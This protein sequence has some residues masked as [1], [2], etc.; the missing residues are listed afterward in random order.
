MIY[1]KPDNILVFRSASIVSATGKKA[2]IL[3]HFIAKDLCCRII[4][5]RIFFAGTTIP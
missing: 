3:S 5:K 2:A 1:A 4:L